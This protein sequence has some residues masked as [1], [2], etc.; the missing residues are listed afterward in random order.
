MPNENEPRLVQAIVRKFY[1]H[2]TCFLC[3]RKLA[4]RLQFVDNGPY[5]K[6]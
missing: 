6:T 3:H 4:L 1:V 2:T 5:H